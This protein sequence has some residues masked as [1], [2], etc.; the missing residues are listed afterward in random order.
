ME[1]QSKVLDLIR[2]LMALTESPNEHEAARAAEKVQELLFKYKLTM[3]EVEAHKKDT[4]GPRIIE[5]E[6]DTLSKKN[7]GRWKPQLAWA[8]AR[9]NF[10]TG[11]HNPYRGKFIFIGQETEATVAKELY[12]WLVI[13]IEDAARRAVLNYRGYSRIP[14]YRRSFFTGVVATVRSRLHD[15]WRSLQGQ[16][17]QSTA[18]VVH[19]KAMLDQYKA[20]QYPNLV[21]GK[22]TN[23]ANGSFEGY[24]DGVRAGRNMEITVRKKVR[25]DEKHLLE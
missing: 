4:T 11:F 18:L 19:S 23:M 17:E 9:Y 2:K 5:I 1:S 15:Q 21:K 8:V 7:W 25:G 14:T 22:R 10:A 6:A 16:S 12:E 3:A 13:Q 24:V 20:Q